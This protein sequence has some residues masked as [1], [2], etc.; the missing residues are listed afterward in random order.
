MPIAFARSSRGKMFE[1]IESVA[2]MISAAPT[3]ISARTPISWSG[4]V[5]GHDAQAR[6][7]EDRDSDLEAEL[8]PEPV[9]EGAEREHEA[10]EDEQVGVDD[11]LQRRARRRRA[12]PAATGARR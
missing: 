9:A 7:A 11:P 4:R 8:A 10:G 3:P 5:D 2:G 6:E 1:M 12:D